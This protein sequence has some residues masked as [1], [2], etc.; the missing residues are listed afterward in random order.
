[1]TEDFLWGGINIRNICRFFLINIWM[2]IAVMIIT[3]L[4]LGLVDQMTY[5]PRYSSTAVVAV[6][7]MSSP[8]RYHTIETVSYLSVKTGEI[9]SVFN[10]ELFQSGLHNQEPSLQDCIIDCLQVANTDLLVMHATSS[11]PGNALKGIWAALDYYSQ[12]SG[13]MTGAPEIKIMLGPEP[14]NLIVGGSKIQKYRLFLC[15][16]S[17]L[18]MSGLLLFMYV[19]R[20]T[21]KT[22][23]IIRKHY[24][25]VRF[26]SLPHIKSGLKNK[27]WVF[28]KKTNH[29]PIKRLALEIKQVLHKCNKNTLFVTSYSDQEGGVAFLSE[30][31][32]ELSEQNQNVL[33]IET[34]VRRHD[35][36]PELDKSDDKVKFTFQDV[37][38]KK[39]NVKDVMI[40]R[41]EFKGYCIQCDSGSIDENVSYSVDDARS[42]LTNCLGHADIV[43]VDGIARY[44]SYYADIWNEAVDVS[45]AL[46]RQEDAD[47]FKV[48]K[49][50]SD[51]QNGDTYFAGCVLFG[52]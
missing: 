31:T 30:L 41:E 34:E 38:Q 15:V 7:P 1:M 6:Y 21:Y 48:D 13:N 37:L 10:S 8:Y 9:S 42:L 32:K 43:L 23:R 18:T 24:K 16:I 51:L 26:F 40:Y 11:N 25:N 27:K 45:I 19:V 20:K 52:F 33:L 39:C 12:F 2:V 49:M 35:N 50:L 29:E 17:G 5:T 4:G 22:E 3:Y 46:C 44:P 28:L 14:P 47:F 36:D